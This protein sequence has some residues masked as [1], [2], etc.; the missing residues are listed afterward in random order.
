MPTEKKR[1]RNKELKFFF[2]NDDSDDDV[3]VKKKMEKNVTT[4]V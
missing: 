4:Q 3:E 1:I 2:Y